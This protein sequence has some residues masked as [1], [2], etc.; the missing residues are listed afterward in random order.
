MV[1]QLKKTN[2][3]DRISKVDGVG[4]RFVVQDPGSLFDC[5]NSKPVCATS[6]LA[7][8]PQYDAEHPPQK[9]SK[10]ARRE[11]KELIRRLEPPDSLVLLKMILFVGLTRR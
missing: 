7:E 9:N 6:K 8:F 10:T 3:F 4:S 5:S 2:M 1:F 11:G